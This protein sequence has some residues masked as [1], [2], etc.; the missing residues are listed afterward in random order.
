MQYLLVDRFDRTAAVDINEVTVNM[1]SD[2][3]G[4][5]GHGI[6]VGS[7]QLCNGG[8]VEVVLRVVVVVVVM[9]SHYL[10]T[11]STF[12]TNTIERERERKAH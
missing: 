1:F 12:I 9:V 2:Q 6:H 7:A 11:L 10:N 4:T 5:S 8:G 3:L